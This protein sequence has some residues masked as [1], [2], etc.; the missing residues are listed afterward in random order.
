MQRLASFRQLCCDLSLV[1][2]IGW[3][4]NSMLQRLRHTMSTP[5]P[6]LERAPRR[7]YMDIDFTD[8]PVDLHWLTFENY[9]TASV[10][11]LASEVHP[12]NKQVR[13]VPLVTKLRLMAHCH[14]EADAQMW[15]KLHVSQFEPGFDAKRVVRLRIC[16]SQP[17]P[18]WRSHTLHHLAFYTVQPLAVPELL[19][20]PELGQADRERCA[21]LAGGLAE[22]ATL[23]HAIRSTLA[24]VAP[25]PPS[26]PPP[27]VAAAQAFGCDGDSG[28]SGVDGGVGGAPPPIECAPYV[29]G[30]W[31]D[32]VVELVGMHSLSV[33]RTASPL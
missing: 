13:W 10:T 29:L 11:V 33:E 27:P 3:L 5:A 8:A 15:H 28:S 12:T 9:Y 32:E 1:G 18:S 16:M 24:E 25:P 2:A 21:K 19:P 23:A 6:G 22:L 4:A 30:E 17:S 14:A 7:Q 20:E 31:E 26:S